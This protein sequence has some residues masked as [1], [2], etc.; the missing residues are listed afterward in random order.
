ME[1]EQLQKVAE[2]SD[3]YKALAL[4]DRLLTISAYS[5]H[6]ASNPQEVK[7]T[8]K[9]LVEKKSA[10]RSKLQGEDMEH[11]QQLPKQSISEQQQVAEQWVLDNL[12]EKLRPAI[13]KMNERQLDTV[14]GVLESMQ[15]PRQQQ[16]V[17]AAS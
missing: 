5:Q 3:E 8:Q 6:L 16:S 9:E 12:K 2:L 13:N 7:A 4:A 11:S 1:W 10:L 17:L 14:L 15:P